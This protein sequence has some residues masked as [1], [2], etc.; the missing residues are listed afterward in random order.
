MAII[1]A[2]LTK[3]YRLYSE[4]IILPRKEVD[5]GAQAWCITTEQVV[6]TLKY[7]LKA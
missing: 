1:D 5:A 3:P 6:E 2:K 7:V 4:Y